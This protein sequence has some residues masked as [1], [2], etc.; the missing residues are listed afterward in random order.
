MSVR[1][2]ED[3]K[4][5]IVDIKY[6]HKDGKIDRIREQF[7]TKKGAERR[8]REI[9]N[10]LE[11]GTWKRKE[12]IAKEKAKEQTLSE[13]AQFF[14]VTYAK[15]HNKRSEQKNKDGIIR[16]Y[17]EPSL[18]NYKLNEIDDDKVE[19]LKAKMINRGLSRKT[20]NNALAVLGKMLRYA[21]KRKR[22]IMVPEIELLKLPPPKTDFLTFEET[23][24]FLKATWDHVEAYVKR[25]PKEPRPDWYEGFSFLFRTGLRIGEWCELRWHDFYLDLGKVLV[26]RRWYE[27]EI[28]TPKSGRFREVPLTPDT[29]AMV[30]DLK[31]RR[32]PKQNDL[33]FCQAN[34]K[35]HA[36]RATDKLVKRICKRSGLRSISVHITR[37]SYA[38]HLV[39][40]GV[41]L[42]VVQ[43]L[44][45]HQSIQM[46]ERY[47]HLAP[48]AKVNAVAVLDSI[49]P[50]QPGFIQS[51]VRTDTDGMAS[52]VN[53]L[54][55]CQKNAPLVGAE[56][57]GQPGET[58]QSEGD[59]GA[60]ADS[61]VIDFAAC[62]DKRKG[63]RE[64]LGAP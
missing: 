7:R 15:V 60:C 2:R 64:K 61:N 59:V 32:R 25:K 26:S 38:S 22:I 45:G 6:R 43:E 8:H 50:K 29:L 51:S 18:G 10:D 49:Q 30:V 11:A 31:R 35:L 63:L 34:G 4:R 23:D 55:S 52:S 9:V 57:N 13:F 41:P 37:H 47:T 36:H 46:T 19:D 16:R 40:A 21:K 53:I 39:M 33:V 56:S 3:R 48:S 58:W 28:T 14:L 24:L 17:L 44:L 27:G 54:D 5:W 42:K 62:R 12:D 20:V 1:W